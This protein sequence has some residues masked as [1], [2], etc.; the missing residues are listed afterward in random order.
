M[1]TD[2][3]VIIGTGD[4]DLRE[5]SQVWLRIFV[6]G[7]PPM[8]MEVAGGARF[9]DRSTTMA[10]GWSLSSPAQVSDVERIEISFVPD[11]R[12]AMFDDDWW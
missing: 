10:F 3:T 7:R 9:A 6:R 2:G 4:D 12:D 8:L 11:S 5:G 1:F